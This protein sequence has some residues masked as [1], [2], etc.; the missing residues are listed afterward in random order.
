[1]DDYRR[2]SRIIEHW[3][4]PTAAQVVD[5]V[6]RARIQL[7]QVGNFGVDFYS[8]VGDENI[9]PSWSGMPLRSAQAN[10]DLA[11][12]VIPQIQEAGASVTGQLST[13]MHF[14][15]HEEGLGLFGDKWAQMWTDDLLGPPPCASADEVLQRDADG[16]LRWR[17]IEGRP[18]RTYR[19][20]MSNPKWMAVLKAMVRKGIE[21]GLDGFNA[22]HHYESLCHCHYCADYARDYLST[23]LTDEA[24]RG[25]FGVADLEQVPDVLTASSDCPEELAARLELLLAQCS[26]LKRKESFDEVFIEYG[27]ALKPGLLLAQWNH[28][29]DLRPHDERCL[30]PQ[31][32]WARGEDY[33]WYSQGPSKAISSLSQ[34]YLAD[35]GLPSRF[36]YAAGG[37][38]PF[39]IN[40]YDYKRWRIWAAEA[41]AHHGTALAYHA[42]PPRL[43][44]EESVNI[45]PEDYYG[46]VIRY[47][48]FMFHHEELLHPA[49][50]WS[51]IALVY[52][53]RA[54]MQR[55]MDCLDA[56]KRLGQHL[57]DGHWF[58]DIILDEQLIE[59]ASDYDVLVL[60]E[61]QRLTVAEGEILQQ[62]VRDGGH[63]V[64]TGKSGRRDADGSLHKEPLLQ[65]WR[66]SPTGG[67]IGHVEGDGSGSSM[68][69]PD[70]P[71]APQ[72]LPIEGIPQEMPIFPRLEDDDF[73]QR[74][75]IEL[76]ALAGPPRLVTDAPWFV[77][78]R[79][80]RPQTVDAVAV[81]WINY[82]Q[83]EEAAL[84]IPIPI[85]PLQAECEIPDGF[86]VERVEW[87]YP[88]MREAV[89]LEH[90]MSG[91]SVRF[92]V[93]RLIVYGMSAL[94]LR[95]E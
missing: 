64:F 85:G 91:S 34:G 3:T 80:W 68:H 93:P 89:V 40:K 76:E 94:H 10:L 35:M 71:W 90:E 21:V 7:V 83:D 53:K 19:G 33:I 87:R 77:R 54:E 84:E 14:G 79:A 66:R 72:T 24:I 69:I 11:A 31:E 67:S 16:S 95:R 57:E 39:V 13:T 59:R 65:T 61:V 2:I 38:R 60:P 32:L 52:P 44:Q 86:E 55:E 48:R 29:Y 8:L 81:H 26:D 46:P 41:M 70:G 27:R 28:K 20:C 37:G 88:E 30:L 78:V 49:T 58:F 25:I 12:E 45:A 36:M 51:Q 43:D 47:Q 74:F 92:A 56:L 50:P 22:T 18:Y 73:G 6:R 9:V 62:F 23:R 5:H 17:T 82:Q 15:N 75:L 1:M 63:L 4:L 42:G